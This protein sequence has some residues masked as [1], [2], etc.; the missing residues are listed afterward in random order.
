MGFFSVCGVIGCYG[1]GAVSISAS[2]DPAFCVAMNSGMH[3]ASFWAAGDGG[4][5]SLEAWAELDATFY[6]APDCTGALGS[7]SVGGSI[8]TNSGWQE[9]TGVLVAPAGTQSALFALSGTVPFSCDDW[10]VGAAAYVDDV[11]VAD[12]FVPDTSP[13]ETTITSGGPETASTTATFEFIASESSSTFECSLDGAAFAS[14]TSPATHSGLAEGPHSFRVR[15]T[16]RAGNTDPTPAEQDWTVDTFFSLVATPDSLSMAPEGYGESTIQTTGPGQLISLSASGQSATTA[17]WFN[18]SVVAA[19]GSSR[20]MVSVG[21]AT[22]PGTYTIVVTGTGT[23]ASHTTTVTLVV[24]ATDFSLSATPL[25]YVQQG[26]SGTGTIGTFSPTPQTVALSATGQPNGASVRFSPAAVTAGA[27]STMTVSVGPAVLWGN[28]PLTIIGTGLSTTHT[29]TITLIIER[30]NAEFSIAASPAS[31]NVARGATG[32]STVQTT[33]TSGSS[34]SIGLSASG[35]PAGTMVSFSPA[36]VSSGGSSTMSLNVGSA[37][38]PGTYT[39]TVTG[40]GTSAAHT[41][42]VALT[43]TANQ[44]PTAGF[45]FSCSALTC[46]FDGGASTDSDGTIAAY[47]WSFGEGTSGSGRT[48]DHAYG[49]AAGYVVTLTVTDDAGAT[50]TDSESVVLVALTARG[51]KVKGLQTVELTWS[52]SSGASFDVYRDGVSVAT[53]GATAY[54]D[55]LNRKGPGIYIYKVCAPAKSTCS[56]EAKVSF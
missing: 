1:Y 50:A 37:T 39:I 49:L 41:T 52:G 24:S 55:S 46:S 4:W 56:N 9:L 33:T 12:G 54:T 36:S 43:V 45:T 20:M 15:A 16:D 18:P 25:I 32:T 27:S 10:C 6:E 48:I 31:L 2:M 8:A 47:K 5:W 19:G 14:C 26:S 11:Y 28:Y 38:S 22:E 29:L 21:T 51:Y 3:S 23:S 53:V 42:T 40:M 34:Q 30:S 7:D 44:P 35:Q 17:V 13:P